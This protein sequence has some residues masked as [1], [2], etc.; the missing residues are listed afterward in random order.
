MKSYA[1]HAMTIYDGIFSDA[2]TRWP[3]LQASFEKDSSYLRRAVESRGL[4]FLTIVLPD[5]CKVLDR[6]LDT[7]QLD[8]TGF[9]QG[10]PMIKK[11]PKLFGELFSL[12]FDDCSMLL[13]DADIDA[14]SF[15]RQL[16]LGC[17]K[18]RI[19]FTVS[20]L[21]ETLDEFF[22]IESQLPPS[23]EETWDRDVP[24]WSR[25]EGHPLWGVTSSAPPPYLPGMAPSSRVSL[26][27]ASLRNISRRVVSGLG[28]PEWWDLRPKHGPGVVSDKDDGLKYEFTNW[29]RKLGLWFPFEWFGSGLIDSDHPSDR[30]PASRLIAVPKSQKGP[31]L[32]CAEPTAHQWIQQSIWRWLEDRCRKSAYLQS[33]ITFRSQENSRD[34]AIDAS[35]SG[36]LATVDLSSASDRISTRLVEY[37]FQGSPILE[38]LHAS[39]TRILYQDLSTSF[40]SHTKLRKFS[41]MGSAVTFPIQSI[42]FCILSVWALR[43][44]DGLQDDNNDESIKSS[45]REVTVFGDDIIIP[46]RALESLKLV[47][48]ECG[49]KVNDSKTF[50]GSNFRESCGIDAFKGY[51][52]TPAYILEPYDGSASSMATVVE[53]SNNFFLKGYWRA[54]ES[55]VS[56][57]PPEELKLLRICG[58]EDG[59]F[60]LRSFVGT[61]TSHLRRGYDPHWQRAYSISISVTSKVTKKRG[62]G[63]ASLSQY[64]FERPAPLTEWSPGEVSRTRVRK[65]RVRVHD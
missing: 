55:M 35:R 12:V 34:R 10:F 7:G 18:M 23:Y 15:L 45:F 31:R 1:D 50:G 54:S 38:G 33:C 51:D 53:V 2:A 24:Q 49:L 40:A 61:D 63:T 46:T 65:A 39:R 30:E 5:S 22:K 43:L 62:Q 32:I 47:L 21:E 9:P 11:R 4:P 20:N 44:A 41:T 27:W 59:H 26:P 60:G 28:T 48:H 16:L 17:K 13:P 36:M 37:I 42:I 14:V 56:S 8:I 52:V 58:S 29:P 64:F 25:R 19:P 6:G 3:S 57:I